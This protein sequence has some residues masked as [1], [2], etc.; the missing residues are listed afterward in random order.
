MVRDTLATARLPAP[1]PAWVGFRSVGPLPGEAAV[2]EPV[3]ELAGRPH[4]RAV[5]C[6]VVVAVG[7][8][9]IGGGH[10]I[11]EP[12]QLGERRNEIAG[13]GGGEYERPTCCPVLGEQATDLGLGAVSVLTAADATL[14]LDA[15]SPEAFAG[16]VDQGARIAR[17]FARLPF[18][19]RSVAT[20]AC[21]ACSAGGE[22][23]CQNRGRR[24]LGLA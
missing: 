4:E 21:A 8:D 5:E 15:L 12:E 3:G 9:R 18:A 17:G 24:P 7:V 1:L 20:A 11:V 16:I 2:V 13:C 14:A 23:P 22:V 6:A 10:H 19:S